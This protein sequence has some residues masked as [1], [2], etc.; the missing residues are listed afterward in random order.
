MV[1]FLADASL[2]DAIVTGCLRREPAIDF[3]SAHEAR[4]EGVP[5]PNVLAF[6]TQENRILVTSDLR[7]MPATS[8]TSLKRTAGVQASFSLNRERPWPMSLRLSCW[9]GPLRPQTNGRIGS[10]RF[11]SRN[12]APLPL[13]L[14]VR[15]PPGVLK[16][17][18]PSW[19]T[20]ELSGSLGSPLPR[21]IRQL[22][23][24]HQI[25]GRIQSRSGEHTTEPNGRVAVDCKFT[26]GICDRTDY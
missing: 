3:L 26:R 7:T 25:R 12:Q 24:F 21:S 13:Q 5:D 8:A 18:S 15:I 19:T 22:H 16:F 6:A 20:L 11:L 17:G 4:L 1:R 14:R 2:H 23:D 10:W 9:Y